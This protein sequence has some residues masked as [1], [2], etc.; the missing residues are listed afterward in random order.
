MPNPV[1]GEA[2]GCQ[3][4]APSARHR[5]ARPAARTATG[6]Y[7]AGPLLARA[8][9]GALRLA[10]MRQPRIWPA[11]ML[12]SLTHTPLVH[13]QLAQRAQPKCVLTGAG[14]LAATLEL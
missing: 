14:A 13:S 3:A 6:A 12:L 8:I 1:L 4:A 7:A 5:A 2:H 9:T 11:A 10:P